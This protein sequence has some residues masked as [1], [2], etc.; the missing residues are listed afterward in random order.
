MRMTSRRKLK[1]FRFVAFLGMMRREA[2]IVFK[3]RRLARRS[4]ATDDGDSPQLDNEEGNS[5]E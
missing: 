1:R 2:K 4:F 3:I 5:Y